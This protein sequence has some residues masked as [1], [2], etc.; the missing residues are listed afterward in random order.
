MDLRAEIANLRE[1]LQV[2]TLRIDK[3]E[4]ERD[5]GRGRKKT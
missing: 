1:I 3:L 5:G 4:E 2:L